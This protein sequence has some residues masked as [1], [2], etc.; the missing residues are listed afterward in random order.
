MVS[1]ISSTNMINVA[2]KAQAQK[3]DV[4]KLVKYV[5]NEALTQA[6]DTF[7]SNVKSSVGSAAVFEGIPLLNFLRRNKK[8]KGAASEAMKTLDG[9]NLKAF[10]K[11]FK[12][13]EGKFTEKLANFI[14]TTNESKRAFVEVKSATNVHAKAAKAAEK[15]AKKG[16]AKAAEKAA[17]AAEKAAATK[18]TAEA[19]KTTSKFG[20]IGKF[21]KSSGAGIMLAFSGISEFL[22]EVVP[23]FKELGFKKG[24]KQLGKSA[25]KVVG[26]TVGF[27]GGEYLGT[28]L[29]AAAGSALAGTKIGAT[30][31]SVFPGFGTAIGAVVGCACGMLGSFIMGKVTKGITGKSEREKAADQ[32]QQNQV[33]QL[34]NNTLSLEELKAQAIAKMQEEIEVNGE[35]SEDSLLAY[36]ALENLNATNPFAA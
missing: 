2:S 11:L 7:T 1:S 19:V 13:G 29:G 36:Q 23:T 21:M 33:N 32:Q 25:V 35:L 31:G 5:N 18:I 3:D 28:A 16:T 14:Q 10:Q 15:A 6:P 12:K 17:A 20:K 8:I 24:M 27:I 22:S 26:D 4:A 30:I 34:A 9:R